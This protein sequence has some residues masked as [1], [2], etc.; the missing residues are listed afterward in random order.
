MI[1]KNNKFGLGNYVNYPE[2]GI[3]IIKKILN[4]SVMLQCYGELPGSPNWRGYFWSQNNT[5]SSI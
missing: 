3:C 1:N 5:N 2:V 4:E